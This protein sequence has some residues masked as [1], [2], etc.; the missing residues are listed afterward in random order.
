MHVTV[1]R[2]VVE[3]SEYA[4][5]STTTKILDISF[6]HEAGRDTFRQIFKY[7]EEHFD[8]GPH[9]ECETPLNKERFC[10]ALEDERDAFWPLPDDD[11]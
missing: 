11:N 6:G 4:S 7:I 9:D 10:Q 1:S 5:E 3:T 8:H 2:R